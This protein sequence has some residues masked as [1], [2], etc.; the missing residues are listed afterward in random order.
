MGHTAYKNNRATDRQKAIVKAQL[1]GLKAAK[2]TKAEAIKAYKNGRATDRQKA[3][4][5]AMKRVGERKKKT[6]LLKKEARES[7]KGAPCECQVCGKRFLFGK[8]HRCKVIQQ[9]KST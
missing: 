5:E 4:V 7:L 6:D 8:K 1:K 9:K 3:M 2:I